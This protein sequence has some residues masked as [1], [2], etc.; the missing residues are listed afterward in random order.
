MEGAFG[1]SLA[2][3]E[4]RT[5][6]TAA[7][8]ATSLHANAYT[9][10]HEI[11][12]AAGR[13]A[14]H[15]REGL[16][17]IAH[18]T[19]HVAQMRG[20]TGGR[21][22]RV[23]AQIGTVL[24]EPSN[25]EEQAD[26]A[27]IDAERAA[28]DVV[29]GRQPSVGPVTFALTLA[30]AATAAAKSKSPPPGTVNVAGV[31]SG[32]VVLHFNA[33]DV[34]AAGDLLRIVF[35]T[36]I[37]M[38]FDGGTV[39]HANEFITSKGAP[40]FVQTPGQPSPLDFAK[41]P[42]GKR[43]GLEFEIYPAFHRTVSE[44]LAKKGIKS[45]VTIP[46][47]SN[48]LPPGV[49]TASKPG[50][51]PGGSPGGLRQFEPVAKLVVSPTYPRHS[52][53]AK[54]S[55]KVDFERNADPGNALI[56]AFPAR[57]NFDWSVKQ[58]TKVVDTGPLLER[59]GGYIGY[60]YT[61]DKEGT[62]SVDV[63]VSSPYFK[64]GKKLHFVSDPIVVIEAAKADR[65][66]FD[67]FHVGTGSD[68]P[69]TR[70]TDGALA[71][72]PKYSPLSIDQEII[73]RNGYIGAVRAMKHLSA[74]QRKA[75][76]EH[77][78]AEIKALQAVSDSVKG[79]SQYLVRGAFRSNDDTMRSAVSMYMYDVSG[80]AEPNYSTRK[81]MLIDTTMSADAQKHPGE[82]R[83]PATSDH[84]RDDESAE[85][86]AIKQA[87]NHV[88][89]YNDYP[90]GRLIL[91]VE[92]KSSGKI[93]EDVV[94]TDN[95]K[96]TAKTVV[97]VG[98]AVAG[99]GLLIASPFTGGGSAP[100]GIILLEVAAIGLGATAV[101]MNLWDRHQTGTRGRQHFAGNERLEQS[102][103]HRLCRVDGRARHRDI[104][105]FVGRDQGPID[106]GGGGICHSHRQGAR[107]WPEKNARERARHEARAGARLRGRGRRLHVD[108]G[109]RWGPPAPRCAEQEE[110]RG[111]G[112]GQDPGRE[113]RHRYD[114]CGA[115][116]SEGLGRRE[117]DEQA[118]AD[119]TRVSRRGDQGEGAGGPG[120]HRGRRAAGSQGRD[121]ACAERP[122]HDA[123]GRAPA[124]RRRPRT[125]LA[126]R[127]RPRTRPRPRR[128]T[129]RRPR[130]KTSLHRAKS[131]LTK[132]P[133]RRRSR[134]SRS[135]R[136][137]PRPTRWSTPA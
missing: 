12:F 69:F 129:S 122:A 92:L 132:H 79:K 37:V 23:P 57:A 16:R 8:K 124:G 4:I 105:V 68:Q 70:G 111:L 21:L 5:D 103:H 81:V 29:E 50:G 19:A 18:E 97:G 72:K 98:A 14:P 76:I 99:V 91:A 3:V 46:K 100:V 38:A 65:Q 28:E 109:R 96:K 136:S 59:L 43:D 60:D 44:F 31:G 86:L 131:H 7:R 55:F 22:P 104:R 126:G 49:G 32:G 33:A 120:I 2:N 83:V 20:G 101:A 115:R 108:L 24:R 27:E 127:R 1:I 9:D 90:D 61:F 88:H 36:Y 80:P 62:F 74:D 125:R 133:R 77:Y 63:V 107:R 35:Q 73:L 39:A 42:A 10:G 110:L 114:P 82:G 40:S 123:Q 66:L 75:Y 84:K 67:E 89:W 15:T 112:P 47:G 102:R 106:R 87:L 135:L 51:T 26:A 130:P 78:E 85:S 52:T 113:G 117:S 128:R 56:N 53:G 95:P 94:Y 48:N 11:G 119:R 58:G 17:T 137:W 71:K 25:P 6:E 41:T 54:I 121:H 13:F 134:A 64:G 45:K 116:G 30:D 118:D 34:L 93:I